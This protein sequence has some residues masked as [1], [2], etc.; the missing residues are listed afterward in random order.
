MLP[1]WPPPAVH[2]RRRS[3][4]AP[5]AS[6]LD[7]IDRGR[8]SQARAWLLV[9][10]FRKA[11]RFSRPGID[12]TRALV[13]LERGRATVKAARLAVRKDLLDAYQARLNDHRKGAREASDRG[14]ET[15]R[16]EQAALVA[17]YWEILRP[18]YREQRGAAQ[19]AAADRS[20][21]AL[22]S[23]GLNGSRKVFDGR[24]DEVQKRLEG[25]VAAPF[26]DAEQARRAAQ[27]GRFIGLIPV[28]YSHGTK[29]GRVTVPFEIQEAISFHSG[30]EAA[31]TDLQYGMSRRD[32]GAT[33]VLEKSI[34]DLGTFVHQANE[35]TNV[36]P[37]AKV[38]AAS[39][40][41]TRAFE[42]A[43]PERWRESTDESD[44]DLIDITLDRVEAAVAAGQYDRAE[45]TRIEAYAFFEFGPELRLRPFDPGLVN[46][47]EGLIWYGARGK[48]GLAKLIARNA[49]LREFHES[50][51]ALDD[52]LVESRTT[53]GE[54]ADDATVISNSALIVFREG[55]EAVL[56][57]A[58]VTASFIGVN[59]HR[60]RPVWLG[61]MLA[62]VATMATWV[63]AQLVLGEF[64]QY[65][66]KLEAVTGLVAVIVLL[67]VLNWF[68]HK[69]YW[70]GK[71]QKQHQ[72]RR[73]LLAGAAAGVISVQTIGLVLLGFTSVY[74]EGF[75][76][77]LFLQ[78]LQLSA[79]T[80]VVLAGVA[81]GLAATFVVGAITFALQHKL[82]Y[83]KMLIATGVLIGIVLVTM[84]G[85]TVR[86]MQGV[87]WV[88]I[89]PVE[90]DPPIWVELWFG[91]FPTVETLVAQLAAALF[92]IGSY[93]AAEYL[94]V[95]RP[96]RRL[97][98]ASA[99]GTQV[100]PVES[101]AARVSAALAS[102]ANRMCERPGSAASKPH[103]WR[104]PRVTPGPETG[105]SAP[106]R[107]R[108]PPP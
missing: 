23:A 99:G 103:A 84:V 11:T 54:G 94:R 79:G 65:G 19:L 81:L 10:D 66:E 95:W 18:E 53:M 38:E 14:F 104:A 51:R 5:T 71:I 93:I 61:V 102:D 76:T 34:A 85:Q 58:A 69:T 62:L 44:F 75:E 27:L 59:R 32:L 22:G 9:R 96:R 3:S 87:G 7:A 36:V 17:G 82:P 101:L 42:R 4:R 48:E 16:A 80:W 55:L 78:S 91:V 46:D 57:L 6:R 21:A 63:V 88:S 26:T 64:Q 97:S 92:V 40:L 107:A 90:I 108:I 49:P 50:R 72:R 24:L 83:K 13:A 47:V 73:K 25:F 29:D 74:R 67:V 89:T 43:T 15:R 41:A 100:A 30:A 20:L 68:V 77:V 2:C 1:A 60:R 33:R 86:T 98:R 56:I 39:E 37:L 31:F 35:Q 28:E 45:Q 8:V 52:A 106:A 70:T 105:P 12:A